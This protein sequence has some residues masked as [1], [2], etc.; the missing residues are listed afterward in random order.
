MSFKKWGSF[1]LT[2]ILLVS[3]RKD[4]NVEVVP[5]ISQGFYVLSEGLFNRNNTTLGY[6]DY[7]T[8]TFTPN[9]YKAVNGSDLGD[10]GT[11]VIQ[12][13]SKLYVVMSG[14]AYVAVAEAG[15]VKKIKNIDF[16]NASGVNKEPRYAVGYKGKV[17]VSNY[18]KTVSVIDTATLSIVKNIPVGDDKSESLAVYNNKLFVANSGFGSGKTV[19]VIDLNTDTFL[20]DIEVGKN[21]FNVAVNSRGEVYI[22]HRSDWLD[23]SYV[24]VTYIID[25]VNLQVKTKLAAA[26]SSS[27][28]R[29]HKDIAYLF[30]SYGSAGILRTYNSISNV[31]I[32]EKF[33]T[34]NT[35]I[36]AP[37][38]LNIDDEK[39]YVFITDAKDYVSPGAVYGFDNTG[40]RIITLS[41]NVG[42]NPNKVLVVTK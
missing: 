28:I 35:V 1:I 3:C 7:Y 21:P 23:P 20:K 42:I 9:I 22:S 5:E 26:V 33:I 17:Y 29:I 19:S 32:K 12:Y 15:T 39:N 36:E 10:N 14:S 41:G 4:E 24:P 40:K 2:A 31:I 27:S 25:G 18:D 8:K 38:G 16:K 13:G 11:D 6:Y 30:D 37:Y 34:D